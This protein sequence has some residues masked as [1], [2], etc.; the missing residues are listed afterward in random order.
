M[1]VMIIKIFT[2]NAQIIIF[3]HLY[4]CMLFVLKK[5]RAQMRQ[6]LRVSGA[7]LTEYCKS[8]TRIYTNKKWVKTLKT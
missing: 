7:E 8:L 2:A 6:I 1:N 5:I 3:S 4:D